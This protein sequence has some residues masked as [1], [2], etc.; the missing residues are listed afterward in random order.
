MKI[1]HIMQDGST[2]ETI[3]GH[4]IQNEEFYAVLTAALKKGKDN[5]GKA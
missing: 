3:A 2:R 5:D 4:I 1:V